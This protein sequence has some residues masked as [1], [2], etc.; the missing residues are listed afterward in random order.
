MS[1]ATQAEYKFLVILDNQSRTTR[2]IKEICEAS[3]KSGND[4]FPVLLCTELGTNQHPYLQATI[5][6]K[7]DRSRRALQIPHDAVLAIFELGDREDPRTI[8][9]VGA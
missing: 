4:L 8:G 6:R 2:A 7:A 3:F 9:F 5:L 1:E